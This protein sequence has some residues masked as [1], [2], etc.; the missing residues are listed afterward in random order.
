MGSAPPV[1]PIMSLAPVKS[2]AQN[3]YWRFE[4]S[5][6]E[7]VVNANDGLI[8]LAGGG[9]QTGPV[10]YRD[11]SPHVSDESRLLQ[12]ARR[13]IY[14]RSAHAEHVSHEFLRERKGILA[15]AIMGHQQP[16]GAAFLHAVEPVAGC[17]IQDLPHERVQVLR[18][19]PLHRRPAAD[20]FPE[21]V[22]LDP[23]RGATDLNQLQ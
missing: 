6:K 19:Q 15:G 1:T 10:Y 9:L 23:H 17:S 11:L 5:W 2:I 16:A 4:D 3:R 13:D 7:R 18:D 8:A 12:H 20:Y 22:G 21:E 14:R